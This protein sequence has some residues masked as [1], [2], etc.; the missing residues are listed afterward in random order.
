MAIAMAL[1]I[2]EDDAGA[3]DAE[4][5][6]IRRLTAPGLRPS[7][8]DKEHIAVKKRAEFWATR[9]PLEQRLHRGHGAVSQ[10]TEEERHRCLLSKKSRANLMERKERY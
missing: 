5:L 4:L 9:A 6:P 7:D 10:R 1:S 2:V 8:I 3:Y